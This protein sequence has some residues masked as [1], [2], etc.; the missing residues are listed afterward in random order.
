MFEGGHYLTNGRSFNH[1]TRALYL[2][3]PGDATFACD[4]IYAQVVVFR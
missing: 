1:V 4:Y 2:Y 3:A